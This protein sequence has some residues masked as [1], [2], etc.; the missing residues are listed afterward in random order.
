MNFNTTV[1]KSHLK[2]TFLCRIASA[3]F[4]IFALALCALPFGVQGQALD[5]ILSTNL[6]EPSGISIDSS[7]NYY[8]ADS[9]NNRIVKFDITTRVS[10]V[11]S[12]FGGS[13]NF[14]AV[15]GGH[16]EARFFDPESIVAVTNGF[17][18]ADTGN[19]L[20]RFVSAEGN[21][22][23]LA[24]DAALAQE[25]I[26]AGLPPDTYGFKDGVGADAQFNSPTAVAWDGNDLI[27]IADTQN[28]A[29]RKLRLSDRTVSTA[30]TGFSSPSGI[31]V[32][33]DGR[34]YVSDTGN[35]AI[36]IIE[37]NG[38]VTLLAGGNSR[39]AS[40]YADN[41]N[42]IRALFAAPR[43][44]FFIDSNFQLLV[45]DSGNA[46][47]RRISDTRQPVRAVDTLVGPSG[48]L[49]NP[50]ALARDDD[51]SIIIVD[52]AANAV[53]AFRGAG[54][55]LQ[56]SAPQ[57]GSVTLTNDPNCAL[58]N[59]AGTLFAEMTESITNS[60]YNN[61]LTIAIQPEHVGGVDLGIQTYYTIGPTDPLNP[62]PDP[63][64]SDAS[65]P[66][67]FDCQVGLPETILFPVRPDTTIKA[68]STRVDRRP[69]P[70]VTA[71]I[72][73]QVANPRVIGD[74]ASA[75]NL[76]SSTTNAL[77][78]YTFGLKENE[79]PDPTNASPSIRY[80]GKPVNI[81]NGTNNIY[82]KMRAFR[83]GYAPS[84]IVK[85]SFIQT[86][87]VFT[88][89]GAPS[90][91]EAGPGASIVVPVEITLAPKAQVGSFQFR[92]DVSPLGTAETPAISFVSASAN[93]FLLVE[94]LA[95]QT[96][97]IPAHPIF[98]P[99]Q[100]A[101]TFQVGATNGVTVAYNGLLR[102]LPLPHIPKILVENQ[103]ETVS[104]LRVDIPA[105]ARHGDQFRLSFLDVS[106]T[107][108]GDQQQVDIAPTPARTIT[109]STNLFYVVGDSALGAGYNAGQF[110]DR[111]LRNDDANNAFDADFGLRVPLHFTDAFN[112]MDAFP[113]DKPGQ[114]G[115]DGIIRYL[116]WQ[117][118]LHRSFQLDPTIWVRHWAE[119]GFL[120]PSA[121]N[122][123]FFALSSAETLSAAT[124]EPTNVIWKRPALLRSG[125]YPGA[126]QGHLIQ[127]PVMLELRPGVR[128]SGL[129]F[130]AKVKPVGDLV[131]LTS[132]IFTSSP[133]IP[134]PSRTEA[135][136][137]D[138]II[139]AWNYDAFNP[140]LS[141]TNMLGNLIFSIPPTALNNQ[142]YEI[143]FAYPDG[144]LGLDTQIDFESIRGMV[145]INSPI[146]AIERISDEWKTFFFQNLTN[147]LAAD[148]FDPD[149]DAASNYIEY[150]DGTNPRASDLV[151]NGLS[152]MNDILTFSWFASTGV[153]YVPEANSQAGSTNWIAVQPPITGAGRIQTGSYTNKAGLPFQI[154]RLRANTQP[155]P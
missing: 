14:G 18:V 96:P 53:E 123:D 66:K 3:R 25:S 50:V 34:V 84:A 49:Q 79:V 58:I 103:I 61:D 21:V 132:L 122:L 137:P 97:Q 154:F 27:Y 60:I 9:A 77:I 2:T 104:Y 30:A 32:G 146:P 28:D 135:N 74:S 149:G 86:N 19:H 17:V 73:F 151:F 40:G 42:G 47:V 43:G 117:T 67:F 139:C 105:S 52:R 56:V 89:I 33:H 98:A 24:G 12:G 138:E 59:P 129:Q 100:S 94:D 63:T 128:V 11:F 127:V 72:R 80:T 124:S 106:A 120:Q 45:A 38:N 142:H 133:G 85:R 68:V 90:D 102:V 136:G 23:T 5:V 57:I 95:V 88:I 35:N 8:I 110:G 99:P 37:T 93:D 111:N 145:Y 16:Q 62:I 140:P 152:E 31:A 87:A 115:G 147:P 130:I 22:Q 125:N 70:V 101:Q 118:I 121:T 144:S 76:D 81:A 108:D 1:F 26:D 112:S 143:S 153:T 107:S 150:L 13:A 20:I 141:G 91:L 48:G 44:L 46:V 6:F 155:T 4:F 92:A 7:G 39:F 71:R 29:V 134:A 119:G 82:F 113:L 114:V 36:K 69:S 10:T 54:L 148:D 83:D 75:F 131:P 15:D 64:S 41:Q 55:Q 51:G 109:V 116:D 126:I 78:W 65:P